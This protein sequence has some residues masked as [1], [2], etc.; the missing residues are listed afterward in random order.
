MLF[1]V[2]FDKNCIKMQ[3]ISKEKLNLLKITI[4]DYEDK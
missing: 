2:L 1:F 3:R 4:I